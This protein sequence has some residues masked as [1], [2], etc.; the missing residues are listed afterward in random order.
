MAAG[1]LDDDREYIQCLTATVRISSQA[2]R[3]LLMIILIHCQ[4]RNPTSLIITFFEDLVDDWSGSPEQKLRQLLQMIADSTDTSLDA[5]GVDFPAV[6]LIQQNGSSEFLE[7]FV[8]NPAVTQHGCLNAEQQ[9]AHDAIITDIEIDAIER[10][11]THVFTLMA[12]AGTGKTFLINSI[13]QSAQLRRL[14]VVPS[15]SS[16]LAASLLGHARTSTM[17]VVLCDV[18]DVCASDV[19]NA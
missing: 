3:D 16:A 19:Q 14:R 5:L 8:S 12:A 13:L 4:P 1:L 17:C 9:C 6:A 10:T 11:G 15:A 7:S 2:T 18:R